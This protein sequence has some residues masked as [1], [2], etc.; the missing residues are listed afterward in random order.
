MNPEAGEGFS[1][2]NLSI[3]YTSEKRM[4]D[5]FVNRKFAIIVAISAVILVS[6]SCNCPAIILGQSPIGISADAGENR[7]VNITGS[8]VDTRRYLVVAP[9]IVIVTNPDNA[10]YITS[11]F[12][13][14]IFTVPIAVPSFAE[15]NQL[16]YINVT[17][18]DGAIQYGGTVLLLTNV[19]TTDEYPVEIIIENPPPN[20]S[21][22][23]VII[24]IVVFSVILASYAL[25][26]RW[27]VGKIVL[28]RASEIR[29]RE[30]KKRGGGQ[31]PP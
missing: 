29:L 5:R 8:V 19:N 12:D 28:R 26:T 3:Q 11:E 7:I 1:I 23:W 18:E 20:Y 31:M 2:T 4:N 30:W 16:L 24:F 22:V 10:S 27:M 6:A 14:G 21:W 13:R 17:S 15:E 25:F 9:L